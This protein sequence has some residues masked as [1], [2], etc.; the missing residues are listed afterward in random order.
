MDHTPSLLDSVYPD[1]SFIIVI[2]TIFKAIPIWFIPSSLKDLI[3]VSGER[4][5]ESGGDSTLYQ[6]RRF[7][8]FECRR[9]NGVDWGEPPKL[10]S[11]WVLGP[12]S[13][14]RKSLG[15]HFGLV[16]LGKVIIDVWVSDMKVV[17]YYWR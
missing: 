3:Q 9:E 6:P 14:V 16:V 1:L 15:R 2:F 12:A 11:P 8:P 5:P 17:G 10:R 4:R 13:N 7:R